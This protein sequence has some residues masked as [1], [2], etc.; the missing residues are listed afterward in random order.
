MAAL[1]AGLDDIAID[2]SGGRYIV[3]IE[4][5]HASSSRSVA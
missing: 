2:R 5:M 3:R 1:A 4:Q